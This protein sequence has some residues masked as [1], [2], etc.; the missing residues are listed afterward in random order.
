MSSKEAHDLAH[1]RGELHA[2]LDA[3]V[4]RLADEYGEEDVL[5]MLGV[6]KEEREDRG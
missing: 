6:V 1:K 4:D 5:W 2:K 3:F